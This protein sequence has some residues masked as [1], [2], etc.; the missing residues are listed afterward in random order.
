MTPRLNLSRLAGAT[1]LMAGMV[2]ANAFQMAYVGVNEHELANVACFLKSDGQPY[3]DLVSIFAANINGAAPDEAS[4]FL[5]P[6]VDRVL[7][8]STQVADVRA[9][10]IK[11]LLSIL[12]NHENSGWSCTVTEAGVQRLAG[13]MAALVQRHGLDGIDIDDEYS[14]CAPNNSSMARV[15]A[16]LRQDPRFKGRLI[17]KALWRDANLFRTPTPSLAGLLDYG[18]EMTYG[19]ADAPGRL[20][21]YVGLGLPKAR[22]G[23]G[24]NLGNGPQAAAAQAAS[25]RQFG[26]GGMMAFDLTKDSLPAVQA[27][28]KAFDGQSVQVASGCLR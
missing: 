7:N 13:A 9:R 25:A 10:G 18:W 19:P 15:A 16:A 3:F 22:L 23:L 27:M 17:T 2:T 11:V 12:G 8:R 28:A 26:A 14:R 5:N 1:V 6:N 24:V 21:P 4:V 20:G